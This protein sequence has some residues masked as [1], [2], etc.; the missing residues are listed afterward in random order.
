MQVPSLTD[1]RYLISVAC[2]QFEQPVS[3]YDKRFVLFVL[4]SLMGVCIITQLN[5]D[6]R[7]TPALSQAITFVHYHLVHERRQ[8]QLISSW[9][10]RNGTHFKFCDTIDCELPSITFTGI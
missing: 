8:G 10:E 1:H 4:G 9:G 3:Y 6:F 5:E 2:I 7:N